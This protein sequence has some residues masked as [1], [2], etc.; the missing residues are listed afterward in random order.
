[1]TAT[2]PTNAEQ[3]KNL[4]KAMNNPELRI[5]STLPREIAPG[6][7]WFG[8]CSV[9][10]AGGR[11]FH[12]HQS[13]YLIVGRDASLLFDTGPP[14]GWEELSRN[15]D[16][17]LVGRTLDFVVPSHPEVPHSGNL[18]NLLRKYPAAIAFGDMK[19]Y[20]LYHPEVADRLYDRPTGYETDL[21]GGYRF[22]L[23]EAIIKDLPNT[24]WGYEASQQVLF[25]ADGCSYIHYPEIAEGVPLHLP[26]ECGKLTGELDNF[27][28]VDK[29]L[30][31]CAKALYWTGFR[32]DSEEVFERFAELMRQY[33]ASILAPTHGNVI[34]DVE[35]V[36]PIVKEA[37]RRAFSPPVGTRHWPVGRGLEQKPEPNT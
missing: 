22:R 6:V 25:I 20:H 31:Y 21:G 37:H 36:L 27:P 18:G 9:K 32:D 30:H 2:H 1:M 26:S 5:P 35:R 16:R 8:H 13:C 28:D 34:S 33:P 10:E 3:M 12:G 29:V 15:L 11:E 14:Q 23:V 4:A 7:H 24:Q 17:W 19:D